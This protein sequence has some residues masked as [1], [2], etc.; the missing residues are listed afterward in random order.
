MTNATAELKRWLLRDLLP[1]V[2]PFSDAAT[3]E[4][5]LPR[6]L[7]LALFQGSVGMTMVLLYGTL[8]RVMVVEMGVPAWLVSLMV[9]LPVLFAPLRALIGFKSDVHHSAFGL[10]RIP[11][12]WFGSLMQ[13]G[14]LA[15][16][17]FALLLLAE[18]GNA[19]PFVG[20]L[21]A[22]AAF[23]LAGAGLHTTQT[24]G[25]ALATDI[26]PRASRPRVVALLFVALQLSMLGSAL[27]L[28][29]LLTDYSQLRLIQ[30]IQGAAVAAIV[31]N[32]I[33]LWK[34]EAWDRARAARLRREREQGTPRPEFAETWRRFIAAGRSKRLL[35]ALGLGTAG[36]T[37]QEILLEPYG[38]QV[39]GL[40]VAETTRLTAIWALGTLAA[41]ALAARSLTRG[42]DTYRLSANGVLIGIVAFTAVVFSDP[43]G[44]PWL[45]RTGAMLIGFGGGLFA[46]GTLTAAMNMADGSAHSGLALGAWG[47]VQATAY[48]VGIAFGGALRDV[49]TMFAA[50]GVFGPVLMGPSVGYAVVYHLEIFL[51]FATLIAIGPL[52]THGG[53]N[54]A[55]SSSRFGIAELP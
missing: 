31:L 46:V 24:A 1:R 23:L 12:I 28:G 22:A 33:A 16:M 51:L 38:A 3:T 32:V 36:F 47:A 37:M 25:L 48:G 42:A 15:F 49:I 50:E 45:F 39:L 10:R 41:F 5:P 53:G 14:G 26:A 11:Y 55:R 52:V 7:R 21:G 27:I 6:L 35:I 44:S 40:S 19:P 18:G 8:N 34:Q 13:F 29:L 2:L 9:A 20:Q 30:V 43:L 4:L 54:G 17:P